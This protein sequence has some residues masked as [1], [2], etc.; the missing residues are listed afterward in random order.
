MQIS[1]NEIKTQAPAFS[2]R[3]D[4]SSDL[5]QGA[6]IFRCRIRQSLR[7]LRQKKDGKNDAERVA[8]LFGLYELAACL[9]QKTTLKRRST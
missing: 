6:S 2:K 8:F 5:T 4:Y 7:A 9:I 3:W 1:L